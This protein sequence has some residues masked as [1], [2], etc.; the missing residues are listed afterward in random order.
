MPGQTGRDVAASAWLGCALAVPGWTCLRR[1]LRT[2]QLT[3]PPCVHLG[4]SAARSIGR[5]SCHLPS[6][7]RAELLAQD[8]AAALHLRTRFDGAVFGVRGPRGRLVSWAALKLKTNRVWEVAV[9]TEADYRGRGYARD[10]VS[11][12]TRHSID[13]GKLAIY[14]HDRDNTTSAFVARSV[15]YQMYA[16]IVFSEY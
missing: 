2:I 9:A 4:R 15:G 13:Q 7:D 3:P 12:A 10:V 6:E 14:V 8:D 16:E 11:A 5:P 1:L